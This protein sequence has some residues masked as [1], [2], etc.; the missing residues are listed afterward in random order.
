VLVS[1]HGFQAVV[2]HRAFDI[3]NCIVYVLVLS[4]YP[5]EN[6]KMN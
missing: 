1:N 2:A 5:L 3:D 4:S 6:C